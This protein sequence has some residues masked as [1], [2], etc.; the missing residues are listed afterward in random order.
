MFYT[1]SYSLVQF[2]VIMKISAK[3]PSNRAW[4]NQNVSATLEDGMLR[5]LVE[6]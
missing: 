2:K 4:L 3:G 5:K 1:F 6:Q